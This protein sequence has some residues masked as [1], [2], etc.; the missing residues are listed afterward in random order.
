[1]PEGAEKV[2]VVAV[3]VAMVVAVVAMGQ[4]VEEE[5]RQRCH[6]QMGQFTPT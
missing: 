6:V 2:E 1:M 3:A 4:A 5:V